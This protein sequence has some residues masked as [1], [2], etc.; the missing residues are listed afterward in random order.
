MA[1]VMSFYWLLSFGDTNNC[2]KEIF[3]EGSSF[4]FEAT[5][6]RVYWKTITILVPNSWTNLAEYKPAKT[7]T[8]DRA[9]IRIDYGTSKGPYTH[10]IEGCGKQG[11]YINLTPQYVRNKKYAESGWGPRDKTAVHEWA[12]LRWGVFDE[13]STTTPFFVMEGNKIEETRCS[14][15]VAGVYEDDTS[16]DKKCTLDPETGVYTKSCKFIPDVKQTAN[17]SIMYK[18]YLPSISFFCRE[19]KIDPNNR[20]FEEAPN[21][22][23]TMCETKS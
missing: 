15:S 3:T 2:L 16:K 11:Q 12:H 8:F 10:V 1:P 17:V 22:Q 5:N 21:R 13:Y 6:H 9:N 23:N 19:D 14:Q 20:H 7:E 18:Q 4:L